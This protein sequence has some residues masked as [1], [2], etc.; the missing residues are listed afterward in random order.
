MKA[1]SILAIALLGIFASVLSC[2]KG[3]SS[4]EIPIGEYSSLTGTT[5]TFGQS[6][7]NGVLMAFDEINK[8]GGVLGKKVKNYVEDDQSRPRRRN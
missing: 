2:S 5:A 8:A 1:R 3:G 4:G 6:T 7:H